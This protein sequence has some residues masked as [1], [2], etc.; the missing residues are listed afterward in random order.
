[1]GRE[2]K[3]KISALAKCGFC[4]KDALHK[5]AG[6]VFPVPGSDDP[7]E[8]RQACAK[9]RKEQEAKLIELGLLIPV[10]AT[11]GR[12]WVDIPKP[13][14]KP[15]AIPFRAQ[16]LKLLKEEPR[17]DQQILKLMKKRKTTLRKVRRGLYQLRKAGHA[18]KMNDNWQ[19]TANGLKA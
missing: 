14:A 1:M 11:A 6:H 13:K 17:T 8:G 12:Q 16:V 2:R 19:V 7:T 9:C 15:K 3:K 10:D 4:G 5:G 18:V